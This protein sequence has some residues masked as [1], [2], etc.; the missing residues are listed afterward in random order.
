MR[1]LFCGDIV[2]RPGRDVVL[3]EL[4][5]LRE[6]LDQRA[7]TLSGGEQQMPATARALCLEPRVLLLDEPTEG[8]QPSMIEQIRQV[9]VR[10]KQEGVAIVLVEQRV[11]AVLSIADR[12]AFIENGRNVETVDAAELR[13]DAAKLT[14]YLGV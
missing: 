14:R 12:V 1:L 6:R 4:P 8:L 10:M 3:K 13:E 11:D 9:I 5:G 2:G 7:E